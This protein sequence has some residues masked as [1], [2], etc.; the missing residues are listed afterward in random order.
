MRSTLS[1]AFTGSKMK[2]MFDF[3]VDISQQYIKTMK[4]GINKSGEIAFEFSDLSTK[5][6]V[7]IIASCAFGIEINSFADPENQ[8]YKV[9][10]KM[11]NQSLNILQIIKFLGFMIVPKLMN[12]LGFTLFDPNLNYLVREMTMNTMNVR[13]E[14]KIIRH[15]MINLLMQAKK[16]QLGQSDNNNNNI[17]EKITEGFA[18]AQEFKSNNSKSSKFVLEDDDLAAQSLI[19]FIAGF[20]TVLNKN[21]KLTVELSFSS[22]SYLSLKGFT[23]VEFYG[24]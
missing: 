16:G 9:A 3:I 1:P 15:D 19:F 18:T 20:S 11:L 13:E 17:E 21:E 23:N 10:T 12:M 8:F 5:F 24:I 14:K 4:D 2:L 6:T 7:D 22:D